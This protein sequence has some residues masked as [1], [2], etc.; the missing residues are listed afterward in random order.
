MKLV[1]GIPICAN[2]YTNKDGKI[3]NQQSSSGMRLKKVKGEVQDVIE[4]FTGSEV[5]T[6]MVFFTGHTEDCQSFKEYVF[7]KLEPEYVRTILSQHMWDKTHDEIMD[8]LDDMNIEL[9][10]DLLQWLLNVRIMYFKFNKETMKYTYTLPRHNHWYAINTQY[11]QVMFIF[12][13]I[14]NEAV[15]FSEG[16]VVGAKAAASSSQTSASTKKT[17]PINEKI[18]SFFR[19]NLLNTKEETPPITCDILTSMLNNP[20]NEGHFVDR[21]DGQ[22]FDCNGK[23]VGF[24]VKR[25]NLSVSSIPSSPIT[26]FSAS[27]DLPGIMAGRSPS[28]TMTMDLRIPP[29]FP[30][31]PAS[32]DGIQV[33]N[34]MAMGG[35]KRVDNSMTN[36]AE[37]FNHSFRD[38]RQFQL[39]PKITTSV[40]YRV[41]EIY[42]KSR[43][44]KQRIY[45]F[46]RMV[47][48]HWMVYSKRLSSSNNER[49]V[50]SYSDIESY[51]NRYIVGIDMDENAEIETQVI[52]KMVIVEVS[53]DL[54][55]FETYLT[56][57]YPRVFSG[58]VFQGETQMQMAFHVLASE[59][60]EIK[61]YMKRELD[62]IKN[63]PS[64]FF[65]HLA[66]TRMNVKLMEHYRSEL[67]NS[68]IIERYICDADI[69]RNLTSKIYLRH[70]EF[71]RPE[72]DPLHPIHFASSSHKSHIQSAE[73]VTIFYKN[74]LY[75]IRI[76]KEGK[77]EI[78]TKACHIWKRDRL[79]VPFDMNE[80]DATTYQARS[81]I[82]SNGEIVESSRNDDE[83]LRSS[84]QDYYV[85][86]YTRPTKSDLRKRVINT[87]V[88]AAMLP[89]HT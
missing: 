79:I 43:K 37:I 24:R 17:I 44:I 14:R 77:Y 83:L 20:D 86:S 15:C 55:T 72:I 54:R 36:V 7:S 76:L 26:P 32:N 25:V 60:E 23:C 68:E 3:S 89:L 56:S 9:H 27:P 30:L 49:E 29:Q 19:S 8:S 69:R 84:G 6:S 82:Y 42:E 31:L 70:V 74:N 5:A 50:I 11:T 58:D 81:F 13:N 63:Y 22:L 87:T 35:Y 67:T 73:M 61:E 52:E 28:M 75:I 80:S 47:V 1:D 53:P 10:Q 46:W 18:S 12:K 16:A 66:N 33:G 4:Q 88:Y 45:I 62:L 59:V 41:S 64:T 21:L 51:I 85:L 39:V 48:S 38:A 78:A 2:E 40:R 57:I 34:G 65:T 71:F